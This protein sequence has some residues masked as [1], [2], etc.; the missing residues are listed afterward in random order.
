VTARSDGAIGGAHATPSGRDADARWSRII[1]LLLAAGADESAD[2]TQRD[3]DQ[4]HS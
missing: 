2:D 1:A 3:E 4:D